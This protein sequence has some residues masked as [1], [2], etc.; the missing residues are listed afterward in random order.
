MHSQFSIVDD[1]KEN[2]SLDVFIKR[3]S[4]ESTCLIEK[5]IHFC[6]SLITDSGNQLEQAEH[7]Q[8]PPKSKSTL[9]QLISSED[10][11]LEYMDPQEEDEIN[12]L[13]TAVDSDKLLKELKKY[14]NDLI[15]V[16]SQQNMLATQAGGTTTKKSRKRK[17]VDTVNHSRCENEEPAIE[18]I[19]REVV[20]E[21]ENLNSSSGFNFEL[22]K[23]DLE[24]LES[25]PNT[26]VICLY[27]D[28]RVSV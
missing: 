17:S 15:R 14:K 5:S 6:D 28:I 18:E 25:S 13:P 20:I 23:E 19:E 16:K 4:E 1:D 12:D 10:E 8:C 22:S 7:V 27:C 26:N 3:L 24:S 2:E 11:V 21:R 9:F